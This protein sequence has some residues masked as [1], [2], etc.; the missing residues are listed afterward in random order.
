MPTDS[1]YS[2]F[3]LNSASSVIEYETIEISHTDF[4]QSYWIVRNNVNG[5]TATDETS[6]S[7][8]FVFYPLKVEFSEDRND[9][10]Y[11]LRI[12]I[13]DVGEVLPSELD[14]IATADGWGEKPVLKYRT[15]RSDDLTQP[16]FGPI[17]LEIG[18]LTFNAT[19][20]SFEAKAPAVTLTKCGERYTLDR[21]PGLRGCL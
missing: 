3:F 5:L 4:T 1:E 8:T 17:T 15:F 20:C 12:D 19:G 10:D 9:M 2:A 18:Q 6:T 13:G 16:L 14:S 11:S 7:R 21:F